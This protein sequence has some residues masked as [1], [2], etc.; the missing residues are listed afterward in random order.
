[1][2]SV[3]GSVMA[4]GPEPPNPCW[5]GRVSVAV[6]RVTP[7][8]GR[9]PFERAHVRTGVV[10]ILARVRAIASNAAEGPT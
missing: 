2:R 1:M 7:S 5:S 8:D 9:L 6:G 3:T 4:G 10:F